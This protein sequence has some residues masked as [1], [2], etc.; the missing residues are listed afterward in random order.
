MPED[1]SFLFVAEMGPAIAEPVF[2][3]MFPAQTLLS[4]YLKE[5]LISFI[6]ALLLGGLD[7]LHALK[8]EREREVREAVSLRDKPRA[9]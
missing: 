6:I 2:Y 3:R 9:A 5:V 7:D 4:A 8:E 1:S